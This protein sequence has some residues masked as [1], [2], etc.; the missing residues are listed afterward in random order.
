MLFTRSRVDWL[1]PPPPVS[2]DSVRAMAR[3]RLIVPPRTGEL[4]GELRIPGGV[5]TFRAASANCDVDPCGGV[6]FSS[7]VSRKLIELL[8]SRF[9]RSTLPISLSADESAQG[10]CSEW[11]RRVQTLP[12]MPVQV[13]SRELALHRSAS[14]HPSDQP[15]SSHRPLGL[16][17]R[18]CAAAEPRWH[19]GP[20]HR[21][22]PAA[23]E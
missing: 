7:G 5:G 16:P 3:I 13:Q 23:P 17:G 10:R 15:A 1:R 6:E 9:C 14:P 19:Y 12:P 21:L 20:R 11:Q 22:T 8:D 2:S 18:R 4:V